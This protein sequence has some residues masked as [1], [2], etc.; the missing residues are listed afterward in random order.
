MTGVYTYFMNE[1][2]RV[3]QKVGLM[4]RPETEIPEDIEGWAFCW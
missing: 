1:Q 4:F 2:F 3:A